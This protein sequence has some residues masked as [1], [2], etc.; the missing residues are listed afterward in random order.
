MKRIFFKN[1]KPHLRYFMKDSQREA[2]W[3]LWFYKNT[4]MI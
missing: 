4:G 1:K 3:E 2:A